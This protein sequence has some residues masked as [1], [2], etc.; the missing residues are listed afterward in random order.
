VEYVKQY[1]PRIDSSV[2][3][4]SVESE[5]NRLM[6]DYPDIYTTKNYAVRQAVINLSK[7]RVT[8]ARMDAYKADYDPFAWVV[9]LAPA[10]DPKI[11]V[12]VLL[13]Q[14]GTSAYAAPV[15]REVIGKYL[16]L[17]KQYKDYSVD[18]IITQ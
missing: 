3:W 9:T 13:F 11:A 12:A 2:S 5:M 7:G 1:L 18:T 17:D 14:G 16:Q 8:A 10:D 4:A 6:K 15:A